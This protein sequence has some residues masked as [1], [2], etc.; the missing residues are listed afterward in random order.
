MGMHTVV[1]IKNDYLREIEKNPQK[2]CDELC[3]ILRR[4]S[5]GQI[6]QIATVVHSVPTSDTVMYVANGG[7]LLELSEALDS[8][9]CRQRVVQALSDAGL[10]GKDMRSL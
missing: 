4:G 6:N 2:F 5:G 3:R 7:G 10:T 8:A 9:I 1:L